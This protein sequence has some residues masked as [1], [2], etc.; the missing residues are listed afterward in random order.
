MIDIQKR[1]MVSS[2]CIKTA[3]ILGCKEGSVLE[4]DME[5]LKVT[6]SYKASTVVNSVQYLQSFLTNTFIISQSMPGGYLDPRSKLELIV[7]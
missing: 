7:S 2:V 1:G 3:I 6:K 4:V 5:S